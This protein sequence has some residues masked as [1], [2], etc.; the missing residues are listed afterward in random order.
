MIVS[1][2]DDRQFTLRQIDQAGGDLYAIVD[3]RDHKL[4][5]ASDFEDKFLR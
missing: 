5:A 3:H 4:D 1:M 2:S